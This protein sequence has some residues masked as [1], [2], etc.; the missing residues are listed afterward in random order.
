MGRAPHTEG[1]RGKLAP[2]RRGLMYKWRVAEDTA[3]AELADAA[4]HAGPRRPVVANTTPG[5]TCPATE[6][7][8]GEWVG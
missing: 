7:F 2:T 5:T 1:G 8:S 6:V 4:A 3:G